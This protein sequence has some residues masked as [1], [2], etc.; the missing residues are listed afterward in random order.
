M[1]QPALSSLR[2]SEAAAAIWGLKYQ[3]KNQ[4]AALRSQRRQQQQQRQRQIATPFGLAKTRLL[5][6]FIMIR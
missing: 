6:A 5:Y 1:W 2:G 3:K 4:I